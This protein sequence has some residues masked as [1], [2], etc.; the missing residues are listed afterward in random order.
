M[1]MKLI[2]LQL[3]IIC[4]S[5]RGG[6]MQVEKRRPIPNLLFVRAVLMFVEIGK[7]FDYLI[8]WYCFCA[9]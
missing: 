5:G 3:A 4:Y 7:Q 9:C 6:V 2:R 8:E 1:S